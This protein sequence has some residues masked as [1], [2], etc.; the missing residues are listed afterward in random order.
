[1]FI[2]TYSDDP[3]LTPTTLAAQ[4]GWS[5]RYVSKALREIYDTSPAALL[6]ATRAER[7]RQ[8]L[9]DPSFRSIEQIWAASGFQSSS[10]ARAAFL[11]QFGKPPSEVRAAGRGAAQPATRGRARPVTYGTGSS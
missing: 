5:V 10:A 9:F 6:R 7:A 3:S 2:S 1:M 4:L 11:E 8:R